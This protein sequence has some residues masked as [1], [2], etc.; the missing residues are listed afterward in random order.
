MDP[1]RVIEL[2]S[3]FDAASRRA[4]VLAAR[5]GSGRDAVVVALAREMDELRRQDHDRVQRYQ[6][7]AEPYLR[8]V[9]DADLSALP[10]QEAH[11]RMIEL[12]RQWLP[13]AAP[14]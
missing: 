8:A 14:V 1:D 10:L 3:S 9:R 12:A 2:A 4:C 7:A 5:R 11:V 13:Q 6:T